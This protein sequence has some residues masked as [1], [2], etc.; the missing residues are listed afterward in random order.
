MQIPNNATK[1]GISHII[2]GWS[3]LHSLYL[4]CGKPN[5]MNL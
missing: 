4:Y 1:K 3:G 2:I 5:T